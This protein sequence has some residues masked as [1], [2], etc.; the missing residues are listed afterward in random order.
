M[1]FYKWLYSAVQIN[2]D[3]QKN[4][5]HLRFNYSIHSLNHWINGFPSHLHFWVPSA[6]AVQHCQLLLGKTS[7]WAFQRQETAN[8]LLEPVPSGPKAVK[9]HRNLSFGGY[10]GPAACAWIKTSKCIS[11]E[12]I[13][14]LHYYTVQ[15]SYLFAQGSL[16][17]CYLPYI[18]LRSSNLCCFYVCGIHR[19]FSHH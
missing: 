12:A 3:K 8:G 19:K 1:N 14:F 13:T 7:W 4:Q 17:I 18:N 9:Q 2:R 11:S 6:R 10:L 16:Y 15:S 5:R